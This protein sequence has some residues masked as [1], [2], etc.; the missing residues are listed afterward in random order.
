MENLEFSI[1]ELERIKRA[2]PKYHGEEADLYQASDNSLYK[3]FKSR[4]DD[5]ILDKKKKKIELLYE[6]QIPFFKTP[7][8]TL[9]SEGIFIG[10]EL[11]QNP[12]DIPWRII[13][14]PLKKR[15]EL[16]QNLKYQLIF[17][18][19]KKIIYSDLK[20][21]NLLINERNNRISFCD[22]DGTQVGD[23]SGDVRIPALEQKNGLYGEDAHVYMHNL[24]TLNEL[25]GCW[26][27]Y[28]DLIDFAYND[29]MYNK[30]E[31][32][33]MERFNRKGKKVAKQ[34]IKCKQVK[35]TS[36]IYLIDNLRKV[37]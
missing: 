17:L 26:D 10:Y 15:L 27:N 9:S 28:D 36:S 7:I 6:M 24:L 30:R 12:E 2:K 16:L 21:A 19:E 37:S 25:M 20:A 34:L 1:K 33:V 3:I 18:S 4:S 32:V 31:N 35:K 11:E 29:I 14:M 22:I 8:R 23:L 13:S 5:S